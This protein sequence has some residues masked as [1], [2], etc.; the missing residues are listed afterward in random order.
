VQPPR[1]CTNAAPNYSSF[2][3]FYLQI[4]PLILLIFLQYHNFCFELLY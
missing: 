4:W 1:P 3:F 2:D